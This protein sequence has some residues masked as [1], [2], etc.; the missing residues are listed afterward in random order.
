MVCNIKSVKGQK[1]SKEEKQQ[2]KEEFL[3]LCDNLPS[4]NISEYLNENV[5]DKDSDKYK[6][7]YYALKFEKKSTSFTQ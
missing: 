3:S 5:S 4:V 6:G 1:L 7:Y 2:K